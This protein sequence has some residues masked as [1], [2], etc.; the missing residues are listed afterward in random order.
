[1]AEGSKFG[2]TERTAPQEGSWRKRSHSTWHNSHNNYRSKFSMKFLP[3]P[4]WAPKIYL[5]NSQSLLPKMDELRCIVS[6][7][8]PDVICVTETWLSSAVDDSLISLPNYFVSRCDK[9]SHRGGGCAIFVDSTW[10]SKNYP[11]L[12]FR[13]L[14]LKEYLFVFCNQKFLLCASMS[15]PMFMPTHLRP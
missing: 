6:I 7:S 4:R 13:F 5:I 8:K 15:P 10:I 3:R 11:V 1:M 12:K 14:G 2:I 9:V